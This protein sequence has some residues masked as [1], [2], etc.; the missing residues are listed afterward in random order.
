MMPKGDPRSGCFDD[1]RDFSADMTAFPRPTAAVTE[2]ELLQEA[3]G[4]P[5]DRKPGLRVGCT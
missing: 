1:A 5:L 4:E 2:G 3:R